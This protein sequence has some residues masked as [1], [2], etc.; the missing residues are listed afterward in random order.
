MLEEVTILR[1]LRMSIN[2]MIKIKLDVPHFHV[3]P[4]VIGKRIWTNFFFNLGMHRP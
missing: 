1:I 2:M 3:N 4:S